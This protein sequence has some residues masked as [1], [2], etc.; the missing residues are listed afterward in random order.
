MKLSHLTVALVLA[1]A[2]VAA[3]AA[4]ESNTP[5][6][7][8]KVGWSH[9]FD[10]DLEGLKDGDRYDFSRNRFATGA[11]G[12]YQFTPNVGVEIGYDWL[13]R[14]KLRVN[15]ETS[16]FT[17]QGIYATGKFSYEVV[18]DFD[19]YT[20][21]GAY[22]WRSTLKNNTTGERLTSNGVSPVFAGGVEYAITPAIA[23]RLDY[24]YVPN[25][26]KRSDLGLKPDNGLLSLGLSYRFGQGYVAPAP[27]PVVQTKVE[28]KTFNLRSDVLFAFGKA[29]LKA[30]GVQAI[31]Q[32]YSEFQRMDLTNGQAVVI[33]FTDRIGSAQ[34][35]QALSERRAQTV[36]NQLVKLGVPSNYIEA[37]GQGANNP[38]TGSQCNNVAPRSAL[39]D[40]LAPDRRVEIKVTGVTTVEVE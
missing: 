8:A 5:Y 16:K 35:N 19:V 22:G 10:T 27:Q 40:C 29:D 11:F 21:L 4:P 6:L 34:A 18:N 3:M 36:V 23:T 15:N 38:V 26:G 33:G 1:G 20:R 13:G 9:Y 28:T 25:L 24:Q 30:E 31:Q 32:L 7:G 14:A 37:Q 17:T 12:G 39:I 2:S